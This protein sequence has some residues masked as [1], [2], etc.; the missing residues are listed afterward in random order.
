MTYFQSTAFSFQ[1]RLIRESGDVGG[2]TV[3]SAGKGAADG[4]AG[5]GGEAAIHDAEKVVAV[6]H[7]QNRNIVQ[8]L[9]RTKKK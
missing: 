8:Q 5:I 7:A 9:R 1:F 6:E 4:G 2:L 3:A